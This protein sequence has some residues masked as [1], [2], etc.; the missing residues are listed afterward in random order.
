MGTH[1]H[2]LPTS[3]DWGDPGAPVPA[4]G[5][6]QTVSHSVGASMGNGRCSTEHLGFL[7]WSGWLDRNVGYGGQRDLA[8]CQLVPA[9]SSKVKSST[10]SS[11]V[12]DCSGL[13][14]ATLWECRVR[15]A[16]RSGVGCDSCHGPV[17]SSHPQDA[18]D[19]E[20]G[21]E[22]RLIEKTT[23][24]SIAHRQPSAKALAI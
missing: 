16:A 12:R 20:A 24:C 14:I 8:G 15:F 11:S 2:G 19:P 3:F 9:S 13:G 6:R 21:I 22:N 1:S 5:A 4:G 17:Y 7:I 18:E 23:R 10:V